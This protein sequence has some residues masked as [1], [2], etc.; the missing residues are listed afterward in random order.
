MADL[1]IINGPTIPAAQS[2]SDIIDFD[3]MDIVRITVPQEYTHPGGP[4]TFQ[5]E[6][7]NDGV[8]FDL[9]DASGAEVELNGVH[10][11]SAIIVSA[12]PWMARLGRVKFRSGSSKTPIPQQVDCKLAC[13]VEMGSVTKR[14]LRSMGIAL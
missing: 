9:Y 5:V 14:K 11:D 6:G 7:R 4:M 10:A 12:V 13:A 1:V 8:F 2:L 3:G